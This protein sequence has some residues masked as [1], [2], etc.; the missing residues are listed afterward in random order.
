MQLVH[1]VPHIAL[2]DIV[3]VDICELPERTALYAAAKR[4]SQTEKSFTSQ[5]CQNTLPILLGID[6]K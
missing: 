6:T 5:N 1:L 4:F 2:K 3:N